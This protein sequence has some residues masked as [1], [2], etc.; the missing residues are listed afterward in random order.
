VRSRACGNVDACPC[1][2][3]HVVLPNRI[4]RFRTYL[5]STLPVIAHYEKQVREMT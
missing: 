3:L 5:E 4:P 2:T 1:L